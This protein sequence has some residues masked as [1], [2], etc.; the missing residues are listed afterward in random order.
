MLQNASR[1]TN[2]LLSLYVNMPPLLGKT[3]IIPRVVF[4]QHLLW[5]IFVELRHEDKSILKN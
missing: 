1:M 3:K 4:V 2:D 5:T